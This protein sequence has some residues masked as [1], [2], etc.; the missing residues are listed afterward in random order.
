MTKR[1]FSYLIVAFFKMLSHFPFWLLYALADCFYVILYYLVGYRRKVVRE[2]LQNSFPE[3]LAQEL[4]T[5]EKEFYKHLADL[6]VEIVKFRTMSKEEISKRCKYVNK[7]VLEMPQYKDKSFICI[8]GHYGNW[9]WV[10]HINT[11]LQQR[12]L[13]VYKP[14]HNQIED[15][16]MKKV[17]ESFGALTVSKNNV[18]RVV[19]RRQKN[20]E[21]SAIGLISDQIPDV[22]KMTY[23]MPFLNQD[24]AVFL[25]A[26]KMAKMFDMPIIFLYTKKIKR[27]HYEI[28]FLPVTT[29]PKEETTYEITHKHVRLTEKMIQESPAY[30]MWSHKRWKW[31]RE[32]A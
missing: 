24:T 27:G 18:L 25:G 16:F 28:K 23:W 32:D 1:F 13:S 7:E 8:Q 22:N 2:N 30:W 21:L 4:L 17:R 9:E 15:E 19:A 6:F 5:I 26:E 10:T 29:N 14:L 11:E 12:I 20:K 31:K 3:K